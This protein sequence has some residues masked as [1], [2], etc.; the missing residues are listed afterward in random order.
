MK[1]LF[2]ARGGRVYARLPV[3]TELVNRGD[4]LVE[5]LRRHVVAQA[6]PGDIVVMAEKPIAA[7][8]G[9]SYALAEIHPTR[10]ARLLSRAVTRTPHGIGLG[11]PETMQL[12]IDEAGL[13][14]ILAAAAASVAGRVLRRKGWFYKVAGSTVEAIDGP[15]P[16]TLPPHNTHAKLGPA[17]PDGVAA[18]LADYL[19]GE[20]GD[21][22]GMAVIDANDL[23]ANVLGASSGVDRKLVEY[24]MRDNPL[25]QG[26]E[27]TPVC[28]LRDLGPLPAI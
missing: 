24:L 17:D 26:H 19:T 6:E 18:K 23:T 15:T 21:A 22:V 8:Q 14:R 4:D 25:G 11:V 10:V 28:L 3:K 7:S 13:P 9:R 20:I 5:V 16:N 27:Q 2:A 1:H 12:A